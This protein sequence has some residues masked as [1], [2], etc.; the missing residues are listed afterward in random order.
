VLHVS[1]EAAV[2]GTLGLV[3]DGDQIEL[4]LPT[5]RLQVLIDDRELGRRRAAMT[6]RSSPRGRGYPALYARHVQQADRGCDFDFL[7]PEVEG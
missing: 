6:P 4:D 1:P 3:R 2:G 7:L 5:R